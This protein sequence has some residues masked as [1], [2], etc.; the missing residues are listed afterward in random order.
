[1]KVILAWQAVESLN[2]MTEIQ[3]MEV[4]KALKEARVE[5]QKEI[6]WGRVRDMVQQEEA[7]IAQEEERTQHQMR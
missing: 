5:M 4:R 1:M 7:R 3:Q 2:M 6:H